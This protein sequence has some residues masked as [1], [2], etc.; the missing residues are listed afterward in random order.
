MRC[1]GVHYDV[2]AYLLILWRTFLCWRTV[3]VKAYFSMFVLFDIMNY[4]L[5]LLRTYYIMEYLLIL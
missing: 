4:F 1:H 2:R 5:M 3:S